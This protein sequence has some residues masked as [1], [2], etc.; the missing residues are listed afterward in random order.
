MAGIS[1]AD[2]AD[3]LGHKDL[4]TTQI[5]AKVQQEH[6]R[7]VLGKLT[8]G[9]RLPQIERCVTQTRFTQADPISDENQKLLTEG[10]LKDES[11]GMAEREGV[12]S[13]DPAKARKDEA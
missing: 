8:L 1:L 9:R 13:P 10:N 4:A 6:L 11:N 7:T 5:Y 3:L 2:I 12:F